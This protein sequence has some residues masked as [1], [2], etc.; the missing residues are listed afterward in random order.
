MDMMG[1][2]QKT[3]CV[4]IISKAYTTIGCRQ[5]MATMHFCNLLFPHHARRVTFEKALC[6]HTRLA[7]VDTTKK[8][9]FYF[10][11]Y[12]ILPNNHHRVSGWV[13]KGVCSALERNRKK[14][15]VFFNYVF[16]GETS[17]QISGLWFTGQ[18]ILLA[19]C[20]AGATWPVTTN[21]HHH[22]EKRKCIK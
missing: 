9:G 16:A 21:S 8:Y 11:N 14:R 2:G 12:T 20:F 1:K 6:H 17:I 22:I 4:C 7:S 5:L 3:S 10:M 13:N 15:N 18:G 19:F